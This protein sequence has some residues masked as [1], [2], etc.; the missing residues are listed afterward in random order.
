MHQLTLPTVR[1]LR[2]LQ[3]IPQRHF[4]PRRLHPAISEHLS[5]AQVRSG[6]R[7]VVERRI[8]DPRGR[9]SSQVRRRG[10]RHGR[11]LV[12]RPDSVVDAG[13][14]CHDGRACRLV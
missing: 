12:P 3:R 9:R 2:L 10:D 7:V 5:R 8:R 13:N 4:S 6:M 11:Y 14:E 1:R